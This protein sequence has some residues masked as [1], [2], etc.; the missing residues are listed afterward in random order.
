MPGR[1]TRPRRGDAKLLWRCRAADRTGTRDGYAIVEALAQM[2]KK[3]VAAV[4]RSLHRS[5]SWSS[6]RPSHL[7]YG[8]AAS[9]CILLVCWGRV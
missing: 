6:C 5:P 3:T 2:D 4:A 7:V 1:N 9:Q 8:Y